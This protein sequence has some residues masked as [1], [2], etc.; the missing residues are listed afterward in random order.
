MIL[1]IIL[2]IYLLAG[3]V[4]FK[5]KLTSYGLTA[6]GSSLLLYFAL[7]GQIGSE[8]SGYFIVLSSIAWLFLSL[9]SLGYDKKSGLLASSFAF[10]TGAMSIIL[11]ST[12]ALSFLIGWEGMTI[13]SFVSIYLHKNSKRTAYMFLVFGELST[14]FILSGFSWASAQSES[15]AFSSWHDMGDWSLIYLLLSL[16]FMIKMAV[17]PFHIWLPEAHSKAPA[18]MSSQLSAVMTLMGLFGMIY[19]L[20]FGIPA[21]WIG[22]VIV[23]MGGLTAIIGAFYAAVCDHVKKLPAYSTVENDGVLIAMMGALIVTY[24]M[25]QVIAGF[26][27]VALLFYA[28]AHTIAKSLLFAVAGHLEKNGGEYLGKRYKLTRWTTLA[29]YLAAISLAGVP[30]M[31]GYIGEWA[32]LESMFQSFYIANM[33]VR[34]ITV[35]IGA[36][37]ALTAGISL[38]AMSK[39]IVHGVER[40]EKKNT[41]LGDIGF[42][43]GAGILLFAGILPQYVFSLLSPV[44]VG[45]TGISSQQYIGGLLGI[46][47]GLLIISGKGFGVLSPTVIALFIGINFGIVYVTMKLSGKRI[48]E[49]NSWNGGLRSEEY[50]TRGHSSILLL[51]Q[52]WLFK[53]DLHMRQKDYIH[54][55]WMAASSYVVVLSDKFRLVLMPGNDR[56]YVFYI[57]IIL[58]IFLFISMLKI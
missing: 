51:T 8:I 3:L 18:N 49:V 21:S 52:R 57:L 5:F 16:G 48:R 6:I 1:L 2:S 23:I 54:Y 14:L 31:P 35:I 9:Y 42:G 40:R 34:L 38:I 11:T 12:N 29:G 43:I 58:L 19:F 39:F 33:V 15:I 27:I 46:P 41:N 55:W 4:G 26:I 10:T 30:P 22:V 17:V 20:Q 32:A 45:I 47:Q 56:R 7:L 53:T 50:P 25:Q 44:A 37:V 28:F 24:G 13:A 36:L